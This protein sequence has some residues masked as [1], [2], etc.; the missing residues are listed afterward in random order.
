MTPLVWWHVKILKCFVPKCRTRE[1]F[2]LNAT[3]LCFKEKKDCKTQFHRKNLLVFSFEGKIFVLIF[4]FVFFRP[5]F[6]RYC[7]IW[8]DNQ[9]SKIEICFLTKSFEVVFSLEFFFKCKNLTLKMKDV[10][11]NEDN[12]PLGNR[13]KLSL[14]LQ[15]QCVALVLT[16]IQLTS[17]EL[18]NR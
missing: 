10:L 5:S 9:Y 16:G 7:Q 1:K 2:E 4:V 3:H 6:H 8:N 12:G 15:G 17:Q 14:L 18:T 11:V 13:P